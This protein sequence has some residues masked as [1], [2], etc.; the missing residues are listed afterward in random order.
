VLCCVLKNSVYSWLKKLF[1]V[2]CMVKLCTLDQFDVARPL[3]VTPIAPYIEKSLDLLF[4]RCNYV[5]AD[6]G[7]MTETMK[8][9]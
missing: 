4:F 1:S 7:V 5:G 8:Y 3:F 9:P 6:V 2:L